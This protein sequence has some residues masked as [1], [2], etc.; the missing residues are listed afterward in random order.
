MRRTAQSIEEAKEARRAEKAKGRRKGKKP[1]RRQSEARK[2]GFRGPSPDVGKATQWKPGQS[3]NPGGLPKDDIARAIARAAF[4]NNPAALVKAF[5]K[6]LSKGNA[7]TFKELGDRA[8]GKIKETI[9]GTIRHE[10]TLEQVRERIDELL[11]KRG[12]RA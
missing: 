11:A 2:T 8:Y 6:A 5:Y 9:G 10:V 3:G 7:Y 1:Q 4:E 12:G